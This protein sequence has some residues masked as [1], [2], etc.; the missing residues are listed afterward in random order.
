VVLTATGPREPKGVEIGVGLRWGEKF[1]R[2]V[3]S[4][5]LAGWCG[6][7]FPDVAGE[8]VGWHGM[9]L[10]SLLRCPEQIISLGG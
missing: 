10:A 2:R 4:R 6:S 9:L 7:D 5:S 1:G 3:G 8:G